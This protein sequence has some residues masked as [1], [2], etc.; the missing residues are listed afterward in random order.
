MGSVSGIDWGGG[1]RWRGRGKGGG[2]AGDTTVLRGLVLPDFCWLYIGPVVFLL[3]D[4]SWSCTDPVWPFVT[5]YLW[6]C[7]DIAKAFALTF[8][9]YASVPCCFVS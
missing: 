1:S 4:M 3:H 6:S 9:H 8:V 7:L 5:T 2:A